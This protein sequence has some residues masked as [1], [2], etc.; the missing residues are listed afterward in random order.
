MLEHLRAQDIPGRHGG[1]E[2]V[3]LLR[4]TTPAQALGVAQ[5]I[6]AEVQ[7]RAPGQRL[8]TV[9]LSIGV[10]QVGF[11]ESITAALRRADQ[12][13]YEAKRQGRACAVTAEGGEEAPVFGQSRP[14]GL[15]AA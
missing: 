4:R 2:F 9:S 1:D 7:R 11:A 15:A 6:S 12:A 14:M 3:L 13:L 10:V 5:R 8:P